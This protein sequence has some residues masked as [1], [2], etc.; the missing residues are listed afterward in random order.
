MSA[1]LTTKQIET[2]IQSSTMTKS[3]SFNP[4]SKSPP[5]APPTILNKDL[6]LVVDAKE[7]VNDFP[8]VI[9]NGSPMCAAIVQ[10][11]FHCANRSVPG[12]DHCGPHGG[13]LTLREDRTLG[14]IGPGCYRAIA[15]LTGLNHRYV[16]M[17]LQG[18]SNP[19][20]ST[21]ERISKVVGV[22]VRWLMNY[23]DEQKEEKNGSD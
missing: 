11:G 8:D 10:P 14:M 9:S 22:D 3:Q 6:A 13:K 15:G 17:V 18:R 4:S 5:T 16:S 19:T 1:A 20:M 7:V 21:M 12:S 23:I 2:E